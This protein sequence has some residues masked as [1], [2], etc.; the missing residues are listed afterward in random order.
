MIFDSESI[1]KHYYSNEGQELRN[2]RNTH[3]PVLL[4]VDTSAS[5]SG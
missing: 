5:M 2:M 4:L 3:T 1:M